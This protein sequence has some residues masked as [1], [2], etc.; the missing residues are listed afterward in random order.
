[1]T[2]EERAWMACPAQG[3]WM[4]TVAEWTETKDTEVLGTDTAGWDLS[5][6]RLKK[7]TEMD[8]K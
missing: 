1:M 5:G 4:S 8:T 3:V 6:R 7:K 2:E